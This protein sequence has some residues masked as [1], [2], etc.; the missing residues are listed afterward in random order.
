[1]V[2]KGKNTKTNCKG[3]Q[4]VINSSSSIH[5][6]YSNYPMVC[7]GALF[8]CKRSNSFV[9]YL[10]SALVSVSILCVLRLLCFGV[11]RSLKRWRAHNPNS[12]LETQ[13]HSTITTHAQ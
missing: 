3:T 12:A 8:G 13:P 7:L 5:I 4:T 6:A 11:C 1:M 2:S 9:A 10:L